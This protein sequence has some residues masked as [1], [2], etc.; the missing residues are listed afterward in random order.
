M[1]W[2]GVSANLW[3][4][5]L[6]LLTLPIGLLALLTNWGW[7]GALSLQGAEAIAAVVEW[8][9]ENLATQLR[10]PGP[11]LWVAVLFGVSLAAVWW[12]FERGRRWR[13][14]S[15]AAF[16]VSLALLV[17]HP[18]EPKF[19]AGRLELTALDVGQ[20]ES[21]LLVLPGGET[22]LVDGG[23]L[24]DYGGV[25]TGGLDIGDAVVSPY[26]WSRSIRRLDVLAVTHWDADHFGGVPALLDN[27]EVGEVWLALAGFAPEQRDWVDSVRARGVRVVPLEA[28]DRRT[29]GGV[30]FS[31]LGPGPA[32]DAV[33]LSR[34]DRSLVLRAEYGDHGFLL[35]GDIEARAE[36]EL[37]ER[38][39]L[40]RDEVL[41]VAHHG[42]A[43]SSQ[44]TFL[45]AVKPTFALISAGYRNTYGHPHRGVLARLRDRG[46]HVLRTDLE[47]LISVSTDGRRLA[48]ET[49]RQRQAVKAHRT[50]WARCPDLPALAAVAGVECP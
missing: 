32:V 14:G 4:M 40:D 26:L 47:G 45:D 46:V 30:A 16:G 6:L 21:L 42:S 12:S 28:G 17:G 34:N 11:P 24:P 39:W 9:A 15:W 5:P 50:E 33:E 20:G 35:T 43:T 27:F 1:S 38:R 23:G 7:L 10:V 48:V 19:S 31:V 41:K 25:R 13:W 44:Q 22:V 29:V 49:Y 2:G 3:I 37:V 18:F 8:H 36:A